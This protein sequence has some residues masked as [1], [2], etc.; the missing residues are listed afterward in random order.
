[1]KNSYHIAVYIAYRI[2]HRNIAP[3]LHKYYFKANETAMKCALMIVFFQKLHRK[4]LD[5]CIFQELSTIFV[6]PSWKKCY[7]SSLFSILLD[8]ITNMCMSHFHKGTPC[9]DFYS[10]LVANKPV[11]QK[12]QY[13]TQFGRATLNI[14]SENKKCK[15]LVFFCETYEEIRSSEHSSSLFH[16]Y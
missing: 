1:M 15:N 10:H 16:S 6:Y 5:F 11:L 3:A 9:V 13:K 7:K 12:T 2:S 4:I 8:L 14:F